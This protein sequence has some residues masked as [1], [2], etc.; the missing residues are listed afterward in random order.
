M[1]MRERLQRRGFNQ[2]EADTISEFHEHKS[3][4]GRFFRS[5]E[6]QKAGMLAEAAYPRLREAMQAKPHETPGEVLFRAFS[7]IADPAKTGE[8]ARLLGGTGNE[9]RQEVLAYVA[10]GVGL[11]SAAELEKAYLVPVAEAEMVD[12]LAGRRMVEELRSRRMSDRPEEA[13]PAISEERREKARDDF[14][15]RTLLRNLY[16]NSLSD[17]EKAQARL[18]DPA[19]DRQFDVARAY[20]A[21]SGRKPAIDPTS[22]GAAMW[23]EAHRNPGEVEVRGQAARD[24]L[25]RDQVRSEQELVAAAERTLERTPGGAVLAGAGATRG[26][27]VTYEGLVDAEGED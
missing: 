8:V 15:R 25:I 5:A 26:D 16:D 6:W 1:G 22:R 3:L 14:E 24:A 23:V 19:T 10:S 13:A 20:D 7:M 21:L 2:K 18:Y 11:D 4:K 17:V 12:S 9:S 27:I